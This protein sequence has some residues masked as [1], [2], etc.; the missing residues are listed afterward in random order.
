MYLYHF[1]IYN[2]GGLYH[3]IKKEYNNRMNDSVLLE[4]KSKIV[5]EPTNLITFPIKIHMKNILPFQREAFEI[6]KDK[7]VLIEDLSKLENYEIVS[8]YGVIC[9]EPIDINV[10]KFI[11]NL[12]LEKIN[13]PLIP[14]KK[15]F[16]SRSKQLSMNSHNTLKRC[17]M[18]VN[19]FTLM[20]KKYNFEI[21][22]LEDYNFHDK[23]KL[24]MSSDV[25]ISTNGSQLTP[26]FISNVN[27]TIIEIVKNGDNNS[28]DIYKSLSNMCN[29]NYNRYSNISED[30]Y[31]NFE[32]NVEEFENYLLPLL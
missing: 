24:F 6:I 20:L 12:F 26:L 10:I 17:M 3:I 21:V 29:L 8:I 15:I 11:R 23:L 18:N 14:K 19:E 2:L 1:I 25:I 27:S 4:D 22:Y 32:I 30:I 31:G 9:Y 5:T 16:I 13:F 28:V 7:F